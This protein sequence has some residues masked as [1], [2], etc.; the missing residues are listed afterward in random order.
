MQDNIYHPLISIVVAVYNAEGYLAKALNSILNQTLTNLEVIII[1]D[2]S[3]DASGVLCD[4]FAAHDKRITVCHTDN[5]GVSAARQ[6]GVLKAKGDY[7]IHVDP[8]DWIENTMLHDLFESAVEQSA[9]MV[10]CDYYV[11][12]SG[13]T[14]YVSQEPT[15]LIHDIVLTDLFK[16]LHGSLCNKLIKRSCLSDYNIRFDTTFSL[17]EDLYYNASLL[18]NDIKIAYVNKAYYHYVQHI[19]PNSLS[20]PQNG[21]FEYDLFLLNAFTNL[22]SGTEAYKAAK[23]YFSSQIVKRAYMRGDMSSFIFMKKC[24]RFINGV[25]NDTK[26]GI[27]YKLKLILSS[28]GFYQVMRLCDAIKYALNNK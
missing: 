8:D 2:G 3:T 9:D 23:Y 28:L 22:L 4:E 12:G 18:K 21:S 1:D 16:H 27:T 17:S 10:I 15:S 5:R 19:N 24:Y 25:L 20:S 13:H 7:V 6:L 26:L 11:E 14:Q